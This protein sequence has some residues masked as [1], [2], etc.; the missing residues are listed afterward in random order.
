M[1]KNPLIVLFAVF[2]SLLVYTLLYFVVQ[3][4]FSGGYVIGAFGMLVYFVIVTFPNI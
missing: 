1:K 4:T 2:V 3:H